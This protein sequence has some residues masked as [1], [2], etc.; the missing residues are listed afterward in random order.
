MHIINNNLITQ[1]YTARANLITQS[2][3]TQANNKEVTHYT[4]VRKHIHGCEDM[5]IHRVK[6]SLEVF[7][8]SSIEINSHNFQNFN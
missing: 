7:R 4:C 8:S 3:T 2:Y 1:S 5:H 6:N